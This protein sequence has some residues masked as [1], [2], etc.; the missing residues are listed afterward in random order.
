MQ[1][2]RVIRIHPVQVVTPVVLVVLPV[3]AAE[4]L[5]VLVMV[6]VT[7]V[8][9]MLIP[10]YKWVVMVVVGNLS[11]DLLVLYSQHYLLIG[12]L[13]LDLLVYLLE[14]VAVVVMALVLPILM[15]DWVVE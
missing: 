6:Q 10:Q 14:V 7:L 8:N 13:L 4:V 9:L 3:V 11:L 5:E 1:V 12:K 15:V 2:V